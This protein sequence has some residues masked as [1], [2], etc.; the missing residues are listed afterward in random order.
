MPTLFSC[1]YPASQHFPLSSERSTG[2]THEFWNNSLHGSGLGNH[3]CLRPTGHM[4]FV[5]LENY[6]SMNCKSLIIN[7]FSEKKSNELSFG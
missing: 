4:I 7:L 2:G 3:A 6:F 1:R 5:R